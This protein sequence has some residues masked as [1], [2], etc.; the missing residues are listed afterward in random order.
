MG[1]YSTY[2]IFLKVCNWWKESFPTTLCVYFHDQDD[3]PSRS[4]H[5]LGNS[6]TY[7]QLT[8]LN[9]PRAPFCNEHSLNKKTKAGCYRRVRAHTKMSIG[10]GSLASGVDLC[11]NPSL[12][13]RLLLKLGLRARTNQ[14]KEEHY[15]RVPRLS[16]TR[17]SAKGTKGKWRYASSKAR[18]KCAT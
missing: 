17:Y 3:L 16:E 11:F 15:S 9:L 8:Y 13:I 7:I 18:L 6:H 14:K 1:S 12:P 10:F 4:R 5:V 2:R